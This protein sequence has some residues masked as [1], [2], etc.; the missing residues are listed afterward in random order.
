MQTLCNGGS[1]SVVGSRGA[2]DI[3]RAVRNLK[4]PSTARFKSFF[5]R[6][7]AAVANEETAIAS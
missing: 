7:R 4:T 1:A 6:M 5:D 3:T 2:F